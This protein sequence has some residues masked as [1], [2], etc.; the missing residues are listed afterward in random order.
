M[1]SYLIMHYDIKHTA[2]VADTNEYI[3]RIMD[4]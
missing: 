3:F 2:E 4:T 1:S